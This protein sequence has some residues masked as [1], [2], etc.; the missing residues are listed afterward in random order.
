VE[1][2]E[3]KQYKYLLKNKKDA[4]NHNIDKRGIVLKSKN[5]P[6]IVS[7]EV[8]IINIQISAYIY[9]AENLEYS[10]KKSLPNNRF[11]FL[12]LIQ[13]KMLKTLA[14]TFDYLKSS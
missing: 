12:L 6:R 9:E 14:I 5:F 7:G 2:A 13:K 1:S 3:M 10:K 8:K 11:L 4:Q